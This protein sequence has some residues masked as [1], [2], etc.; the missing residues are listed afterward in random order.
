MTRCRRQRTGIE[1]RRPLRRKVLLG[2]DEF[3]G[4]KRQDMLSFFPSTQHDL[5]VL[6]L[7]FSSLAI[8]CLSFP[9]KYEHQGGRNF[10]WFITVSLVP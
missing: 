10:V 4:A 6:G 2:E 9:L 7:F 1:A 5:N 8:A 3:C